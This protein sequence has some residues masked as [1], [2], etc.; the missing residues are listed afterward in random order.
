M[1]QR[2]GFLYRSMLSQQKPSSLTHLF[3]KLFTVLQLFRTRRGG[4]YDPKNGTVT[5]FHKAIFPVT[6]PL[7]RSCLLLNRYTVFSRERSEAWQ[8]FCN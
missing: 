8:D 7:T 3:R 4:G 5:L 2:G 6:V 1:S